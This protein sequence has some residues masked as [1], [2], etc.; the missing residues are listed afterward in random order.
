MSS[1]NKKLEKLLSKNSGNT[2]EV[3]LK[4]CL[5]ELFESKFISPC[6]SIQKRVF[7]KDR[8]QFLTGLDHNGTPW[9]YIYTNEDRLLEVCSENQLFVEMLFES[10]LEIMKENNWGGIFINS[11]SE[12]GVPIP[13]SVF[14]E[15]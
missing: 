2:V 14:N 13:S 1:A 7:G 12:G 9:G 5:D 15:R 10:Y 8:I 4:E 11:G 3:I 6:V